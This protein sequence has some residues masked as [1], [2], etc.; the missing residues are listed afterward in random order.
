MGQRPL[1]VFIRSWTLIPGKG[2]AFEVRV[3]GDLIFSKK[4]LGRHAN[5]GEILDL[6]RQKLYALHPEAEHYRESTAES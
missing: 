4:S 5:P 3:N 2:G 1:E 6:F